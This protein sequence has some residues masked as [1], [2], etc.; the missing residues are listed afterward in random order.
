MMSIDNLAKAINLNVTF[1]YILYHPC[2][3]AF[4]EIM[5]DFTPGTGQSC[6]SMG[7]MPCYF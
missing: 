5:A 1:I 3:Q 4:S 2:V 7:R 6:W